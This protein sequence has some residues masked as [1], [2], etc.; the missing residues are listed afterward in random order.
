MFG[1][2]F[3]HYYNP[4]LLCLIVFIC[5]AC[6]STSKEKVGNL[7]KVLLGSW[8]NESLDIIIRS[9]QNQEDSTGTFIVSVGSWEEMMEI[10]PII[11]AFEPDSSY[12]SSYFALDGSFIMNREGKWWTSGDSLY[13]TDGKTIFSYKVTVDSGKMHFES[14]LD[15]DQDGKH[16]DLYKSIQV[17]IDQ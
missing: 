8:E 9:V 1:I 2:Y 11:T 16:D 5:S 17:K 14:L 6:K 7:N 15:W 4:L 10:K 3:K 13:M 12:S